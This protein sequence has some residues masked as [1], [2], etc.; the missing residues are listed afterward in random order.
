MSTAARSL[1][2]G[3]IADALGKRHESAAEGHAAIERTYEQ[4]ASLPRDA[5]IEL[6]VDRLQHYQVTVYRCSD[7]RIAD[8]VR[9]AL[10][11]R[12]KTR[13]LTPS[14]IDPRWLPPGVEFIT[15][16]RLRYR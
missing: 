16:D 9:G 3:R 13:L 11:A 1:V 8:A 4:S 14:G 6:F 5:C 2:L 10:D 12:G 7:D 15:D